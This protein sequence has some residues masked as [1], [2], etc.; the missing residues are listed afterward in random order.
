MKY[1]RRNSTLKEERK[2]GSVDDMVMVAVL[3]RYPQEVFL[4][5]LQGRVKA[6]QAMS[7]GKYREHRAKIIKT[8]KA[9]QR[10]QAGLN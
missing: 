2:V 7:P 4:D 9:I 5:E 1:V 8:Q 3:E 10:R 6:L